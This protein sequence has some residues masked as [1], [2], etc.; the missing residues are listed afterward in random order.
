[1]KLTRHYQIKVRSASSK[2]ATRIA[3]LST[4]LGYPASAVQMRK[5][6]IK[7][8]ADRNQALFV[9]EMSGKVIGWLQVSIQVLIM[10]D[11]EAEVGGFVVDGHARRSGVG[12]LL[13]ER[14]EQWSRERGCHSVYLR[15]NIIREDA[16]AFYEKL[17]YKIIKTQYAFRKQI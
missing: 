2:D 15:T 8:V 4:Q 3:V 16:H 12:R 17:G 5:R 14:A 13:M 9:A 7:S 6:I 10:H 1:M 11:N